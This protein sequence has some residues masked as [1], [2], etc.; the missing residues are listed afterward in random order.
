MTGGMTSGLGASDVGT[1][2][3]DGADTLVGGA[4]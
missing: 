3:V 2:V 4:D 1:A